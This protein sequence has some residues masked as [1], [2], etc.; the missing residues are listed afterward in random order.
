MMKYLI[1]CVITLCVQSVCAQDIA[2]APLV[3][4]VDQMTDLKTNESFAYQCT[5]QTN[6]KQPIQWFQKNKTI[7]TMLN[8]VSQSGAWTNITSVGNSTYQISQGDLSGTALF[9]RTAS[10]IFI[11]ID[12]TAGNPKAMKTR[13]RVTTISPVN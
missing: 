4:Q 6:G 3:W 12:L 1:A 9:E 11:T 7:T 13:F 10:G 2:S 5:F 8:I